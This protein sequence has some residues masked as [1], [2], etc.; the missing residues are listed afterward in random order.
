MECPD[1]RCTGE[2]TL[3]AKCRLRKTV[4]VF[5]AKAKSGIPAA[6]VVFYLDGGVC[7]SKVFDQKGKATAKWSGVSSGRHTVTADLA[8][9]TRLRKR[10][11]CP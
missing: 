1:D 8:C 3:Q 4:N 2:E 6:P 5:K 11:S 9:G 7:K 10:E